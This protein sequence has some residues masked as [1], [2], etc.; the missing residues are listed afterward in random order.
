[1]DSFNFQDIKDL[2][3]YAHAIIM[4]I[5]SLQSIHKM[6]A[7]SYREGILNEE[8]NILCNSIA[9]ELHMLAKMHEQLLEYV[10]ERIE[11]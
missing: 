6:H 4:C 9:Y 5:I 2:K 8:E 10:Y 7:K 3:G 11:K 1:M